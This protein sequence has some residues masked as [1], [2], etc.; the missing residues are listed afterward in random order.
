MTGTEAKS[1]ILQML[2]ENPAAP[3]YFNDFQIEYWMRSALNEAAERTRYLQHTFR[4]SWLA[5]GT[6]ALGDGT[7]QVERLETD[8]DGRMRPITTEELWR[9]NR[10]WRAHTGTP[11]FYYMDTQRTTGVG[12]GAQTVK[13]YPGNSSTIWYRVYYSSYP[14]NPAAYMLE[15]I[16]LPTWCHNIVIYGTLARAYAA[17]AGTTRNEAAAAF[18][19]MLYDQLVER[20]RVRANRRLPKDWSMG[21]PSARRLSIGD[22]FPAN[23]PEP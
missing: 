21:D 23:I 20:L 16:E 7:I 18:Y 12:S 17:D 10:N 13:L 2:G 14:T 4:L 5:S 19:G 9:T 8:D 15:Q 11:R 6:L 1:I 22:I 3:A